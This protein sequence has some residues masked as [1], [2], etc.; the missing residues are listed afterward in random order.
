MVFKSAQ[1]RTT[2]SPGFNYGFD[3]RYHAKVK[4]N[5]GYHLMDTIVQYH[6]GRLR[7]RASFTSA[8]SKTQKNEKEQQ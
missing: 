7:R 1:C 3:L 5:A 2:F 4:T 8:T 6:V